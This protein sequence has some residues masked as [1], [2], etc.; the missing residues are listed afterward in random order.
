MQRSASRIYIDRGA[1]RAELLSVLDG[2]HYV[3]AKATAE[4]FLQQGLT[5]PSEVL[6]V[7][8]RDYKL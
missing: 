6:R 5:S 3:S 4:R 8:G 7:L 2:P 1:S